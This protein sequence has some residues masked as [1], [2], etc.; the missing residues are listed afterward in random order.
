[1][2]LPSRLPLATALDRCSHGFNRV[3]NPV[4][5]SVVPDIANPVAPRLEPPLQD[6]HVI[7][8]T[9]ETVKQHN[10]VVG[11]HRLGLTADAE[12]HRDRCTDR[13]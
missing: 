10:G 9:P 2:N 6:E 3:L 7:P 13:G 11:L 5:A 8:T 1:M 4:D 12:G